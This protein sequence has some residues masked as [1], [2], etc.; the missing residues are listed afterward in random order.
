MADECQGQLFHA[1]ILSGW[2][3]TPSPLISNQGQLYYIGPA[4]LL[5]TPLR[6]A[7]PLCPREGWDQLCIALRHQYDHRQQSISRMSKWHLVI[8]DTMLILG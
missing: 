2:L 1:Y 4:L 3:V 7:F 6:S 8:T 5:L